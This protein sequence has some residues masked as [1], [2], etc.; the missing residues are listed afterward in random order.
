LHCK[1]IVQS[2]TSSL[3]SYQLH[4]STYSRDYPITFI[5]I[6]T[7]LIKTTQSVASITAGGIEQKMTTD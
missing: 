4:H 6:E 1:K 5:Q 2:F 7:R 3:I